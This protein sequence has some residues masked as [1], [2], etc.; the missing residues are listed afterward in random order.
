M[1][2]GPTPIP[3]DAVRLIL[4]LILPSHTPR[5]LRM[6]RCMGRCSDM[7]LSLVGSADELLKLYVR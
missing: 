6:E 5:S 4:L 1:S 3:R 2:R 7:H